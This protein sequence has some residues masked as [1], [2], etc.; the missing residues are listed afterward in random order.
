MR[1]S[2]WG[3][4]GEGNNDDRDKILIVIPIDN[5]IFVLLKNINKNNG[6]YIASDNNYHFIPEP[7]TVIVMIKTIIMAITIVSGKSGNI[8]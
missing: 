8:A 6:K 7:I 1:P 4:G 2:R 3:R 5:E